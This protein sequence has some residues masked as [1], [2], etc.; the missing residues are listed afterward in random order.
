MKENENEN[1]KTRTTERENEKTEHVKGEKTQRNHRSEKWTGI[2]AGLFNTQLLPVKGRV[3]LITL[4][5]FPAPI[6]M[7]FYSLQTGYPW[8]PGHPPDM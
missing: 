5:V 4:T 8:C 6:S 3:E 7:N 1:N 2:V